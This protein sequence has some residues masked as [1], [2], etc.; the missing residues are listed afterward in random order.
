MKLIKY[1]SITT[2]G[3]EFFDN[4]PDAKADANEMLDLWRDEAH[5]DGWDEAAEHIFVAKIIYRTGNVDV[6]EET[7]TKD[8]KLKRMDEWMRDYYDAHPEKAPDASILLG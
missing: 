5:K 8:M 7:D 3:I 2:E 1:V 6:D 4:L